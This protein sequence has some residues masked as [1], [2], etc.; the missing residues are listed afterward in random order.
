MHRPEL[1]S[2]YEPRTSDTKF[3]QSTFLF[4]L[5]EAVLHSSD[6]DSVVEFTKVSKSPIRHYT[7]RSKS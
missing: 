4:C 2:L 1:K 6:Y 7:N 3:I 5:V